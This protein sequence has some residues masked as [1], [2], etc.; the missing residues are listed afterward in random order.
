VFE[1]TST[2]NN[3]PA[4]CESIAAESPG[5]VEVK[6]RVDVNAL[7]SD[8]RAHESFSPIQGIGPRGPLRLL[9]SVDQEHPDNVRTEIVVVCIIVSE[10]KKFVCT[11]IEGLNE[12]EEQCLSTCNKDFQNLILCNHDQV[13]EI[14]IQIHIII[15]PSSQ[16]S[17]F[18]L[19]QIIQKYRLM[20]HF[21]N[22]Y[23]SFTSC[24]M[25]DQIFTD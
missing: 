5:G 16:P 3:S 13:N 8:L 22:H 24:A 18:S 6:E 14:R 25:I 11:R 1:S 7:F 21:T 15:L 17:T 19:P 9:R 10:S 23:R 2:T 20:K 4:C 12:R